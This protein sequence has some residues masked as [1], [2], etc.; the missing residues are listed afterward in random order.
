MNVKECL[1]EFENLAEKL[2]IEVRK[3]D[4]APSGHCKI[5]GQTILYIDS[6]SKDN[7]KLEHFIN[8]FKTVDLNGIFVVP[9]IRMLLGMENEKNG[10]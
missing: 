10:W 1:Q 2:D 9:A 4:G 7:E 6:S 8:L 3:T 5:K